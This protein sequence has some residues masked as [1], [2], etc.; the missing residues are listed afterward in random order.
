MNLYVVATFNPFTL[1]DVSFKVFT[2]IYFFFDV[3]YL[4]NSYPVTSEILFHF[5]VIDF[6]SCFLFVTPVIFSGFIITYLT[7]YFLAFSS[8]FELLLQYTVVIS[9]LS[10]NSPSIVVT[11]FSM[12]IFSKLLHPANAYL[13]IFVTL[14]GI[15]I[16]VNFS[17]S[18]KAPS[19][20]D[21]IVLGN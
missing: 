6:S 4:Y 16:V 9:D 5:I 19:S 17:Q 8:A 10:N 11:F 14:L 2:L 18:E 21:F 1:Y 13:P 20:I 15:F 12:Y 3:S 7:L